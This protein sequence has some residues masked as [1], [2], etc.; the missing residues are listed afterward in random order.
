MSFEKND[1]I[2]I[3]WVDIISDSSWFAEQKAAEFPPAQCKSAGYFLNETED[4][5]R[6]SHTIQVGED[7]DRDIIVI[8]KGVIRNI[9]KLIN[10]STGNK[11]DI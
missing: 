2:E 7:K 1:L 9:R 4:L 10:E 11:S 6:L 8:P 3:E 5:I